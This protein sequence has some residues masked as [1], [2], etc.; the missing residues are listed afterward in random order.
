MMTPKR[1]KE[2]EVLIMELPGANHQGSPI[3]FQTYVDLLRASGELVG[4]VGKLKKSLENA[5]FGRSAF[6]DDSCG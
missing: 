2:I 4:E 3:P 5:P 6:L 1:F